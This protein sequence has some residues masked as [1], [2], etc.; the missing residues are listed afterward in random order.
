MDDRTSMRP[1]LRFLLL[2]APLALLACATASLRGAGAAP[3]GGGV[4]FPADEPLLTALDRELAPRS[5]EE[6][7]AIG[8]AAYAKG[9]YPRAA[10]AFARLADRFP[11][12]PRAR[13]AQLS[14]GLAYEQLSE[15]RLALERFRALS[16]A[17]GPEVT[18][19]RFRLAECHY[20]L[21][22]R[23]DARAVLDGIA[24][25]RALPAADRVRALAQRG[26]LELE[27]DQPDRAEQTLSEAV[28]AYRAARDRE[29]IPPYYAAQA[30]YHLGETYRGWFHA[31]ALDPSAG[32][33]RLDH[34]LEK[35]SQL[36]LTAQDHYLHTIDLGE[37]RWAVA[38]GCR[39]GELYDEL[40]RELLDAPPPPGL[41]EAQAATYRAELR[42][43]VRV[44]AE[45]AMN[46]YEQ[47]LAHA[48][49][50]GV[51][52]LPQLEDA[53]A[54]LARLRAALAEEPAPAPKA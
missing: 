22:E 40:R 36:L 2:V 17:E 47:T 1:L 37:D 46:A 11:D 10:A 3:T 38:A 26:V 33:A 8:T 45:K 25:E 13:E 7:F 4:V 44:L 42:G 18:E 49:R 54:A 27:L 51:S 6:L 43:K 50:A 31:V 24:G 5:A 39:V 19:A 20:H 30:Q 34:D 32:D 16:G 53:R 29:R 48:S 14:A 52:D 41:D 21:G 9:T 35:K 28:A 23:E 15:W 12:S